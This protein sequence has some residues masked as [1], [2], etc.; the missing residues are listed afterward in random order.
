MKL[1]VSSIDNSITKVKLL[2][3]FE[4]YGDVDSVK[5]FRDVNPKGKNCLCFIEMRKEREALQAI[6]ALDGYDLNGRAMKVE[7]SQDILKRKSGAAAPIII[8]DDDEDDEEN[9]EN[10]DLLDEVSDE[11]IEDDDT[12][13]DYYD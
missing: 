4:E 9:D 7:P 1:R 2:H 5:I 6:E 11:E 13:E 8:D 3:L 10:Q 12:E